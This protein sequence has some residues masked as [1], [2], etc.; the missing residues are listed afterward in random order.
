MHRTKGTIGTVGVLTH[1]SDNKLIMR[2][3][4]D[5]YFP[6]RGFIIK[7]LAN[8]FS[9]GNTSRATF[10]KRMQEREKTRKHIF[11]V[12]QAID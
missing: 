7:L 8:R 4:D 3:G 2:E 1:S 6:L 5:K 10:K 11:N 9:P 12:H